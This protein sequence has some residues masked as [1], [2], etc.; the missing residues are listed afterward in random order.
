MSQNTAARTE[1]VT[2]VR[3]HHMDET[4]RSRQA[5]LKD[6]CF[7]QQPF[8]Q[9]DWPICVIWSHGAEQNECPTFPWLQNIHYFISTFP[10]FLFFLR[11]LFNKQRNFVKVGDVQ[12]QSIMTKQHLIFV[13]SSQ[14]SSPVLTWGMN[15][16]ENKEIGPTGISSTSKPSHAILGHAFQLLGIQAIKRHFIHEP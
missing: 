13:Q 15:N 16:Q 9:G 4:W 8:L 12:T 2:G 11:F 3:N 6:L 10:N 5:A 7:T 14:L 1:T